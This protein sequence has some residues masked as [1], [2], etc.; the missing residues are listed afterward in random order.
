MPEDPRLWQLNWGVA[1]TPAER[2][3]VYLFR[4]AH[5]YRN[6]P[7][8]PGVDHAAGRVRL[9]IDD[10]SAHLTGRDDSGS[11]VIVGTGTRA[12]T[13]GLPQ[14]WREILRLDVLSALDLDRILIF[15]R[16][17][18][19]EAYRGSPVFPAFFRFSASYFVERGYAYSIHYCAP[20]L[21]PLY[22]RAGYRIYG[23]G[24]TMRSG[25][26]RVPMILAG[27][28]AAYLARVSPSFAR[29]VADAAADGD[30]EKF[31]AVLPETMALPLCAMSAEE[32]LMTCRAILAPN[33]KRD[34]AAKHMPDAAAKPA[35]RASLL[36][37]RPGDSPAHPVDQPLI[38]FIL[39]GEMIVRLRDEKEVRAVPGT[40]VNGH[41]LA[42]YSA[43]YGGT[44]VAFGPGKAPKS[45]EP[46]LPADFWHSLL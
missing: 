42:S 35:R 13:P 34:E 29:V 25:L 26:F 9:P 39:E 5:Y 1:K 18:E 4:H 22:E 30:L 28:D 45:A 27:A 41:V 6:L 3:E 23:P 19:H 15:A 40:F 11:L 21:V 17:V 7:D 44:V 37:L 33:L 32:R 43:P 46:V 36:T 16:L 12:S 10:V 2:E 31:R 8:A 14:E 38:W 24:Y 20:A